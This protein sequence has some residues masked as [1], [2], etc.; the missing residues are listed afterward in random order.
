L[1][2]VVVGRDTVPVVA[3]ILWLIALDRGSGLALAPATKVVLGAA[4]AVGVAERPVGQLRAHTL[5][6]RF[7]AGAK[8][9]AACTA[10]A[11][12]TASTHSRLIAEFVDGAIEAVVAGEA[13]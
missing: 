12:F 4:V 2:E 11:G 10:L 1:V 8:D 6:R 7:I 3:E 9:T 13:I 5:I